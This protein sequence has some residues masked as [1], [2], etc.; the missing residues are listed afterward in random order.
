MVPFLE[1]AIDLGREYA[2]FFA[3]YEYV[4]D[5][6]IDNADEGDGYRTDGS[7]TSSRLRRLPG[8]SRPAAVC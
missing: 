8:S 5:P 1:K 6:H 3:P 7:G 4:A 2:D